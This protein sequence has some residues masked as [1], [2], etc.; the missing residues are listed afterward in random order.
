LALAIEYARISGRP[1]TSRPIITNCPLSKRKPGSR[2]VRKL[3][4]ALFQ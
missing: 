3:K 4:S 2:V 1:S